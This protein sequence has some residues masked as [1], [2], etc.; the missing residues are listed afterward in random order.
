MTDRTAILEAALDSR[1]DG[2]A[3]LGLDSEVVFWNRAAE[4]ITGFPGFEVLCQSIPAP[5]ESL[6][7]DTAQQSDLAAGSVQPPA[8]GSIVQTRHKLGHSIQAMARRVILRDVLGARIG[9]AVVFHPAESL[10]AL[11][12]GDTGDTPTEELQASQADL[13]ERLQFEFD[14]FACGGPP[15]AFCGSASIRPRNC[16]K[17]TA[18][19]RAT[20]CSTKCG[21]RSCKACVPPNKSVAGATTNF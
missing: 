16:A 8:G 18:S 5:L 1:P 3:L 14:D 11:P 19:P 20:P 4:E 6:L 7:L 15:S 17:R 21:E 13:E 12:H 2:I 9:T 10:D